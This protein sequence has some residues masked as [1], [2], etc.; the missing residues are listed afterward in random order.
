MTPMHDTM[1]M[2]DTNTWHHEDAWHHDG[3]TEFPPVTQTLMLL[4]QFHS[5][6]S[7]TPIGHVLILW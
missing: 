7:M 5:G 2:H 3:D 6:C 1:K 4:L